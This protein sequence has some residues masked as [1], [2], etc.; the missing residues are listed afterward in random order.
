MGAQN[1]RDGLGSLLLQRHGTIAVS[2]QAFTRAILVLS[3]Y[4]RC[5]ASDSV[6]GD[7]C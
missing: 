7:T 3:P 5:T 2:K 1:L 6:E 4:L